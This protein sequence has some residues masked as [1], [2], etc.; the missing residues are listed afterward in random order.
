MGFFR[1]AFLA[2]VLPGGIVGDNVFAF[3]ALGGIA[4][5]DLIGSN[6]GAA[7]AGWVRRL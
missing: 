1:F 3:L 5:N 4:G 7:W 6:L 2:L